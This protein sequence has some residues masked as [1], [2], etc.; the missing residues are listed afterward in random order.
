VCVPGSLVSPT[1]CRHA[2]VAS[3]VAGADPDWFLPLGDIQYENGI[4]A[5]FMATSGY[6]GSFSEF[7]PRTLPVVGNHEYADPA[8]PGAGYFRYFDPQGTGQFG[9]NPAGYYTRVLSPTWRL[10]VLNSECSSGIENA[11]QMLAGGCGPGSPEFAWLQSVLSSSTEMCT[12]AAFHRPRWSTGAES[13]NPSNYPEMAPLW[14]LLAQAGVELAVSGH[15]HGSEVIAPIGASGTGDP[16]AD[17]DGVR[18]FVAGGGGK[19]HGAFAPLT[20][21]IGPLVLAR[22]NTTFGGLR[23]ALHDGSYDWAYVP[24]AG[25]SFS[26]AGTSGAFSGTVSCR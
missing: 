3:M 8:G 19:N 10:I 11:G 17:P 2:D 4:Y 5:D 16:V 25:Q 7:R 18:Q 6:D 21:A 13:T 14:D 12:V 15:K 24:I 23:L 22:D 9:A 20:G 26:N 1:T